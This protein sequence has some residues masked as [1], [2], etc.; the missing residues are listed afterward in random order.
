MVYCFP[1][2]LAVGS[3]LSCF[4]KVLL[5]LEDGGKIW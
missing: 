5:F 3:F 4:V 1:M 2:A